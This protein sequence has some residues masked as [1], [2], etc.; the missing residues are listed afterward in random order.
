MH[1]NSHNKSWGTYK[2]D[3]K[4]IEYIDI[5][6]QSK[7]Y[8]VK[9]LRA[10]TNKFSEEKNKIAQKRF[11]DFRLKKVSHQDPKKHVCSCVCTNIHIYEVEFLILK[12]CSSKDTV[13]KMKWQATKSEAAFKIISNKVPLSRIT[14]NLIQNGQKF[15]TFVDRQ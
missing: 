7:N 6:Y 11:C 9:S 14:N 10:A 1:D 5:I 15:C 2:K 8:N 4:L 12:I 3:G 13:K